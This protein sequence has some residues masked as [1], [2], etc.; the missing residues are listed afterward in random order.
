[1]TE[2]ISW[3]QRDCFPD[4]IGARNDNSES[5]LSVQPLLMKIWG[6]KELIKFRKT[7]N[8]IQSKLGELVGVSKTTVYQREREERR[9]SK[10]AKILMSKIEEDFGKKRRSVL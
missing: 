1:M 7:Y 5:G 6:P 9:S 4:F 10:T 3:K 8:L 2:A